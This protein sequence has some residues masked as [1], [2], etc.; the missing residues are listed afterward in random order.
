VIDFVS[1]LVAALRSAPVQSTMR[2]MIVAAIRIELEAT[3]SEPDRLVDADEAAGILGMSVAAV[4]K[5]ALR[6]TLP[7]QRVGRRLRFRVRS[8]IRR[9]N[10]TSQVRRRGRELPPARSFEA[11]STGS[12]PTPLKTTALS[13]IG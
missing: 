10:E 6:G 8:L 9:A 2:E 1:E 12:A 7:C 11:A 4:R 13:R 3:V 5:A